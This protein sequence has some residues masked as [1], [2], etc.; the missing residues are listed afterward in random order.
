M[1]IL[2]I[3]R[4]YP[5]KEDPQWG[6]FEQDQA[7]ALCNNGN[8]V[9]ILSVDN[10]FLWRKRKIGITHYQKAG[11]DYYNIFLIPGAI[12]RLI[13]GHY[14]LFVKEMQIQRLY[15]K[16]EKIHGKPDVI[17]G[18]F[19]FNTAIAVCLQKK[20]DIPLVGIE[21]AGRFNAD[22]LDPITRKMALYAYSNAEEI[23]TVSQTL[24]QR[25]LYHFERDSFVV[26]NLVNSIFFQVSQNRKKTEVFNFSS[27]GSLVYGKGFDLLIEAFSLMHKIDEKIYLTIIGEGEERGR[28]QDRIDQL[29]LSNN[30]FLVGRKTK[31]EIVQLLNN[32][33]A[34]ILPSRSENFSVSVLEALAVGLPVIATLCGG[35]KECID[36]SNG[37]LVP[38]E[39]VNSL[40]DAMKKM[41][42]TIDKY[43]SQRIS[44]DCFDRFSPSVIATQL[45]DVF[46][47]AIKKHSL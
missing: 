30:I 32:S 40:S 45:I 23:I 26:H 41:Y 38:I 39:D 27:I 44:Q 47:S 36:D 9:V 7:E 3:A 13:L 12:T 8:K 25:I 20:Y 42:Y 14:N 4:G 22:K 11:I 15:K 6:C 24:K 19:F 1:Y 33:S 29:G 46:D 34:F 10:R 2:M 28:L 43:D 37:L 17:Y 35:I 21:H 16:I 31:S 5:T 18:Q